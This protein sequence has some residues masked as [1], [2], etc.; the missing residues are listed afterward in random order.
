MSPLL[1]QH[2][3]GFSLDHSHLLNGALRLMQNKTRALRGYYDQQ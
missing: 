3:T 2:Y 1:L